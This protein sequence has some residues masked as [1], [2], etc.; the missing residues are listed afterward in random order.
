MK[1]AFYKSYDKNRRFFMFCLSRLKLKRV[2]KLT[3][4]DI[5]CTVLMTFKLETSIEDLKKRSLAS[6]ERWKA[7]LVIGNLRGNYRN[8]VIVF[9]G[10]QQNWSKEITSFTL[11]GSAIDEL[12]MDEA[13]NVLNSKQ[14]V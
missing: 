2:G 8:Q 9:K 10:N 12:I 1:V 11:E 6:L 14:A 4:D 3:R 13:I 5:P 7:D